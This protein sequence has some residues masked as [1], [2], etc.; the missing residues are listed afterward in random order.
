MFK[1][2]NSDCTNTNF[3]HRT[4]VV[5]GIAEKANNTHDRILHHQNTEIL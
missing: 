5:K 4:L 2:E 3:I 1:E